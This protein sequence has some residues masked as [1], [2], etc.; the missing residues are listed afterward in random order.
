MATN[1]QHVQIAIR[2]LP[3]ADSQD[4]RLI[5][6][7]ARVINAVYETAESGL[8]RDGATRTSSSELAALIAAG[9]IAVA[10]R[11]GQL[12]GSVHIHDIAADAGEFG[13]LVADPQ[14][15]GTGV[16]RALLEFAERHSRE[17]GR[18]AI[19]LELLVPRTWHHPHKEFLKAWYGRRGYRLIRSTTLEETHPHLAPLLATPCDLNIYQKP[20]PTRAHPGVDL[21]RF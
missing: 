4:A 11:N 9:Q 5:D 8:W 18:R 7:L 17:R 20:L 3:P 1:H 13:M 19:Q 14:H 12:A 2:L 15:R 21:A 16:G 10:T 6:D